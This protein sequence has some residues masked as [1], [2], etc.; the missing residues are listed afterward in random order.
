MK[1]QSLSVGSDAEL[2]PWKHFIQEYLT[3]IGGS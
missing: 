2:W 1:V 3:Q